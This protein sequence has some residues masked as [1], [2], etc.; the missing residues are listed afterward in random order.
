M[1]MHAVPRYTHYGKHARAQHGLLH[2]FFKIKSL[3]YFAVADVF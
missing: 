3:Y 1:N 2:T